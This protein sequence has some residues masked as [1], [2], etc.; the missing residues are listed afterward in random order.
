MNQYIGRKEVIIVIIIII[1][2]VSGRGNACI[3]VCLKLP[4]HILVL[5]THARK[6]CY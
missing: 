3:E 2:S 6:D 4:E 5:E 1:Y